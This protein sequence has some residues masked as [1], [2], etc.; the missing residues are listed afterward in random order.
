MRV[1]LTEGAG[2]TQVPRFAQDDKIGGAG[3]NCRSELQD[4][5][6]EG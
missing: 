2:K 6:A 5:F 1:I 3:K 4:F